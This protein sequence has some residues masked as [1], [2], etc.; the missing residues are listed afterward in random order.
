MGR[1]KGRR[2]IAFVLTLFIAVGVLGWTGPVKEVNAEEET[3]YT[4]RLDGFSNGGYAY[5]VKVFTD[6]SFDSK[7]NATFKFVKEAIPEDPDK[8]DNEKIYLL[9]DY[10]E[11]S[12][13]IVLN[14]AKGIG[15]NHIDKLYGLE[16]SITVNKS[17]FKYDN[18][19]DEYV[20][21]LHFVCN[22]YDEWVDGQY[23]DANGSRGYEGIGSWQGS[24]SGT[25]FQDTLGW[26]P[27]DCWLKIDSAWFY[28]KP[29]GYMAYNEWFEVNGLWYYFNEYGIYETN[30]WIDGYYISEDGTQTYGPTGS[31]NSDST[32]WW[33]SDT[34]G[35]YPSDDEISI[36]GIYYYFKADGYMACNEWV[37]TPYDREEGSTW[38]YYDENG[39]YNYEKSGYYDDTNE[40]HYFSE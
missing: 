23:F 29:D 8:Y 6:I 15:K 4:I 17:E 24:G 31:W 36:D 40:W 32:G 16:D 10:N 34:S 30:C 20:I 27:Y 26:Y 11:D 38:S 39:Q 1:F 9:D 3:F 25:W 14:Y 5:A 19:F 33:Y 28:F 12:N 7:G 18:E 37:Q 21:Y 22:Y 35:W 13:N 2:I